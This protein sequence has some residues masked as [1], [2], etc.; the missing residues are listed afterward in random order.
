MK[1]SKKKS[2]NKSA[3]KKRKNTGRKPV[4]INRKKAEEYIRIGLS[5]RD[6]GKLLDVDE[7]TIRNRFSAE[8]QKRANEELI[9]LQLK[10]K[11]LIDKQFEI[12]M[13][14]N[15]IMLIWLGKNWLNQSDKIE[16][17]NETI[18]RLIKEEIK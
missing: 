12:A 7:K 13:D 5:V 4:R 14:G 8:L 2:V 15:A 9:E 17:E 11:R 16:S 1:L 3:I 18:I 6:I 10:K